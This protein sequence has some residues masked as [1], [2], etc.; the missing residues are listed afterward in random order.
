MRLLVIGSGLRAVCGDQT[1]LGLTFLAEA[2]TA[3]HY[4]LYSFSDA[5]AALVED[6]HTGVSVGGELVE[7]PD[8]RFAELLA[9]EP[10]GIV[11]AQVS[12]EDGS[13]VSSAFA[14]PH[15]LER[16]DVVEITAHGDFASYLSSIGAL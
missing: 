15:A 11:Q 3:P 12:L 9:G 8:W 13:V 6:R 5:F 7:V 4:R 2:R 10:E 14:E 16:G 1:A